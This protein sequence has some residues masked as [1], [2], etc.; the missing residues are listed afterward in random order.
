MSAAPAGHSG[1]GLDDPVDGA[2]TDPGLPGRSGGV[3][4][5]NTG[6]EKGFSGPAAPP[7][8][9]AE[10]AEC[11]SAKILGRIGHRCGA[12][13]PL[14]VARPPRLVGP[15]DPGTVY[16]RGQDGVASQGG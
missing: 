7:Q 10:V 15:A 6:S 14:R 5:P 4:L 12:P 8:G 9:A 13:T 3:G 2:D 16:T 11:N 1:P